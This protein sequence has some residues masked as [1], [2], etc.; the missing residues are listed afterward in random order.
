MIN[1]KHILSDILMICNDNVSLS[2]W[3]SQYLTTWTDSVQNLLGFLAEFHQ[4]KELA[5]Y[6]RETD[7]K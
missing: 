5:T 7:C 6:R 4:V 2:P 3:T 1:N